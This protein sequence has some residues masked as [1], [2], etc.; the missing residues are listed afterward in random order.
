MKAL[1][2]ILAATVCG[3]V[4][5][6]SAALAGDIPIYRFINVGTT[7]D[8]LTIHPGDL[9]LQ[10][11]ETYRF[12]VSNPSKKIHVVAAPELAPTVR[13]AELRIEGRRLDVVAP[14]LDMVT[15]IT[16]QPGQM[17]EWTFT[18][19][20]EGAYKFGCDDPVHAAAG[21]HAMIEV[22]TQEVL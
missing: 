13:T 4:L 19:L 16:L 20:E 14:R 11:G 8:D 5:G 17:I 2:K 10:V 7:G 12:V 15:G 22:A 21:M 1:L 3:L 9:T 18:P 6:L